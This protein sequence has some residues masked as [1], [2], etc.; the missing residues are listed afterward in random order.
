META[1]ARWC[2]A[3][4]HPIDATDRDVIVAFR[5]I[6]RV[7]REIVMHGRCHS[8]GRMK[9]ELQC[10]PDLLYAPRLGTPTPTSSKR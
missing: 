6:D 8:S 2:W 4:F 10:E 9:R 3:C 1:P 5:T 7:Q